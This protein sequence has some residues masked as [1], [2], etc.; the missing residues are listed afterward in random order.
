MYIEDGAYIHDN[1][2]YVASLSPYTAAV[3]ANNTSYITMNGGR[4]VDN[5]T[6]CGVMVRKNG[7]FTMNGGE[8]SGQMTG[9]KVENY[10][11]SENGKCRVLLLG[12]KISNSD[13][14]IC[15]S[16]G[17][18]GY[19]EGSF[20]YLNSIM[21]AQGLKANYE[22]VDTTYIFGIIRY[23]YST[24]LKTI[25]TDESMSE[26]YLGNASSSGN[27]AIGA[28]PEVAAGELITTWFAA[29]K[30][31]VFKLI[32]TGLESVA[33]DVFAC[34]VPV[35][36]NGNAMEGY[37]IFLCGKTVNRSDMTID[38]RA[39]G[40]GNAAG[41]AIGLFANPEEPVPETYTLRYETSGG[42]SYPDRTGLSFT[43]TDLAPENDPVR[44]G[45]T[46]L[47]WYMDAGLSRK[48][49]STNSYAD[50]VE[51]ET[52][53]L[54]AALYAAWEKIPLPAGPAKIEPIVMPTAAKSDVKDD[55]KAPAPAKANRAATNGTATGDEEGSAMRIVLL[56]ALMVIFAM[57]AYRRY[58]NLR[59]T[60]E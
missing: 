4:I 30:D 26:V 46:F 43:D 27:A 32:V 12:G 45:Y 24:T 1:T 47:G 13:S 52:T 58:C 6:R 22:R 54:T 8:I 48:Y 16:R 59:Q 14:D 11:A 29:S 34:I 31:D 36:E 56:L 57:T 28:V 5:S 21:T 10:L 53:A 25:T 49:E 42:T 17:T 3:F 15:I 7:H 23:D 50:I 38:V 51:N 40:T 39:R 35:D 2:A 33:G 37:K 60:N 18:N 41:Y 44:N 9:V 55:F 19:M 20:A